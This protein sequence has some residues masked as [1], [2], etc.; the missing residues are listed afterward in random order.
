MSGKNEVW[1]RHEKVV[2]VFRAY[3]PKM[4][5]RC[6]G[7]MTT[8]QSPTIDQ[9]WRIAERGPK[10]QNRPDHKGIEEGDE[11][12]KRKKAYEG[13]SPAPTLK[14]CGEYIGHPQ[15]WLNWNQDNHEMETR[16]KYHPCQTS[17]QA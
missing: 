11:G 15:T 10:T 13:D 16:L 6:V 14:R 7:E 4:A 1:A 9:T 8:E 2:T 12:G 5:T 3:T 17:G